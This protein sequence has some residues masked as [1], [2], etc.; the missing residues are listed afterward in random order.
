MTTGVLL[1]TAIAGV[2]ALAVALLLAWPLRKASPRLFAG[3]AVLVPVL[4]FCLYQIVGTP[5][6][7]GTVARQAPQTLEEAVAQLEADL[8]R[9]PRQV[10]GWRLLGRAYAEQQQ[11][12]QARDAFG[13]AAALVPDDDDVQVEYAEAQA[14]ANPGRRFDEDTTALL[15]RVLARTPA[16]QRARWFL[17]IAQRQAG[18][19]AGAAATW[20]PLLAQVDA[21]TAASLRMQINAARAEAGLSPLPAGAIPAPARA[22]STQSLTVRVSLDPDFAARVRLAGDASVFVIARVPDGPPMPVAV[23]R[24]ALR[25]L[26]LEISLDDADGP[27]P[28]Q[29]LSAL[30]E[31]ELVARISMRG[32]ATR[33]DGDLESKP[34]R[35]T[36]P[37][38]APV[39]LV[40]GEGR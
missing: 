34:V 27:M 40:I 17:G 11:A 9:D 14:L 2:V 37:A 1:F 30:E 4:G 38:Q 33:Q 19:D 21:N 35:V 32:D 23:E 10:E 26:P 7:I 25:D 6:G 16:H 36:L 18:D 24:H 39:E 20:T 15:R 3:V 31:V 29:K 22:Q 28:T 13:R 5:V 8:A 12:D